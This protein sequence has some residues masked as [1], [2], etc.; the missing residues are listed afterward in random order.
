[1]ASSVAKFVPG[2]STPAPPGPR[3]GAT[4]ARIWF[5]FGPRPASMLGA[6]DSPGAPGIGGWAA[7]PG[8]GMPGA[9]AVIMG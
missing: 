8:I 4:V 1:M 3:L 5:T 2:G 7:M 9:G 6:S